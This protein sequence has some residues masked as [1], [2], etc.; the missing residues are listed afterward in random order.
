MT[1]PGFTFGVNIGEARTAEQVRRAA[2]DAEAAGFDALTVADHVGHTAPFAILAAAAMVTSRIRLRT[3][4]LDVAF[5]NPGLLAREAATVDALSGG[6]LDLG[7]GAGHMRDEHED[8]GIRFLPLADRISTMAATIKDVRRRLADSDHR[9]SAV[10][11]PIPLVVG[12]MSAAGLEVAAREADVVAL[13]GLLQVPGERAGTFTVASAAA[14]DERLAQVRRVAGA[15]RPA[16]DALLQH[17][18]V[19]RPPEQAAA[20]FAERVAGRI[21][22]EQLLDT[23]FFLFA[24]SVTAAAEELVRRHERWGITS[25]STHAASGPALSAVMA[26]L[27]G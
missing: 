3:Y 24:P 2:I 15:R 5:W 25:W 21:T 10:Q 8:I 14:T 16:L 26:E 6:R 18:I 17:V 22:V 23:P 12:A 4:V 1:T 13:S 11:Q 9:P 19:D 27:R 7:L 20:E